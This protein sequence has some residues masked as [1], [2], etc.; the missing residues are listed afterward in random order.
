[1]A[2]FIHGR[3]YALVWFTHFDSATE[4]LL[5]RISSCVVIDQNIHSD[6]MA[7]DGLSLVASVITLAVGVVEVVKEVRAFYRASAE[8]GGFLVCFEIASL[9]LLL[10]YLCR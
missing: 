6:H 5:Q 9:L 2:T 7:M 4:K 3:L 10:N 1:M 8:L